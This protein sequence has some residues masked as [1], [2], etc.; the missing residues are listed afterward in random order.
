MDVERRMA[1]SKY[2]PTDGRRPF[3]VSESRERKL[4]MALRGYIIACVMCVINRIYI[5]IIVGELKIKENTTK[6]SLRNEGCDRYEYRRERRKQ[7]EKEQNLLI[8]LAI[9]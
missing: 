3:F 7:K 1:A 6:E 8:L 5:K 2:R 9:K 4:F